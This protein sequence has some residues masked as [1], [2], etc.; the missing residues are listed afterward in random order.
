MKNKTKKIGNL[1]VM[2]CRF[3]IYEETGIS[4]N[5]FVVGN[6]NW[7]VMTKGTGWNI[8]SQDIHRIN[9]LISHTPWKDEYSSCGK[10][11][12]GDEQILN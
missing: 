2:L 7:K 11:S 5:F 1:Y 4:K 6:G 10:N 8:T 3:F 9:G 12:E